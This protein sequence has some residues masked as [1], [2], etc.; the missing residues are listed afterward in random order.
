MGLNVLI[1]I[2][3]ST[4]HADKKIEWAILGATIGPHIVKIETSRLHEVHSQ[5]QETLKYG[6]MRAILVKHFIHL[7]EV[8]QDLAVIR[9]VMTTQLTGIFS[10]K[11]ILYKPSL[12]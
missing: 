8:R 7:G 2:Q 3:L 11:R 12:P 6:C 10:F 4:T 5:A 1:Q 9:L